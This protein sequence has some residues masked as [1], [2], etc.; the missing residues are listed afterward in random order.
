MTD[1]IIDFKNTINKHIT[2]N[3]PLDEVIFMDYV[4]KIYKSKHNDYMKNYIIDK[5][6]INCEC[7]GLY[8]AHQF[9]I[10]RKSKR[11]IKHFTEKTN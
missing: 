10:H 11:H 8:K 6:T 1:I 3:M 5:P 2:E 4:N 9:H 7:G